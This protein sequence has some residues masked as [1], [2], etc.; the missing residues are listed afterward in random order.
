MSIL[1]RYLLRETMSHTGAGLVVVLALF[2]STR[3]ASL[4][5]DAAVGV[6]PGGVVLELLG[7][8][9]VMALPSLLPAMFYLGVLLGL[10]RLSRDHELAAF[11]ASGISW[12]QIRRVVMTVALA[13]AVLTAFLSFTCRPWAA[14]RFDAVRDAAVAASGLDDLRP[15]VF[16]ERDDDGHQVLFAE[17]RDDQDPRFLER[18]FVRRADESG[19]TVFSAARAVEARDESGTHRFLT[20]ID[21]IQYEVNRRDEVVDITRFERFTLRAPIAAPDADVGPQS[22]LPATALWASD[23]RTAQAELQW[24]AA[25]PVSVL[26]LALAALALVDI[27][28]RRGRYRNV[29]PALLFYLI[30]RSA[31]GTAKNWVVSGTIPVLPGLWA[32]HAAG[33]AAAG[34]L[35]LRDPAAVT[36]GW[37]PPWTAWRRPRRGRTSP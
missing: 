21:G 25:M 1:A 18:V 15:G 8:R 13:A 28:P 20:L 36:N 26:V 31:L 22:A 2:I 19:F 23:T 33:L 16:Y 29:L 14:A 10:N 35:L 32:V 37:T 34:L 9:T 6:L 24:R 30:F 17:S 27:D 11:A 4:L 12:W 7:L 5:G 3:L